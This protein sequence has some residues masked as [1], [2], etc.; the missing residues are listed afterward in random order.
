MS[1]PDGLA[2]PGA[3]GT[4]TLPYAVGDTRH[5]HP[6]MGTRTDT[7]GHTHGHAHGHPYERQPYL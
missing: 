3:H 6:G 1:G 2:P 4:G 7:H 5:G